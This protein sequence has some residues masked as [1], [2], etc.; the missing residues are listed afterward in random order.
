MDAYLAEIEAGYA[1][2]PIRHAWVRVYVNWDYLSDFQQAA[3][4]A[5]RQAAE[6]KVRRYFPGA[7]WNTDSAV[8]TY[9]NW[10]Q[11]LA[12][13]SRG[14]CDATLAPTGP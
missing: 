14:T 3:F 8:S 5:R 12:G 13:G 2:E 10:C 11:G 6:Q 9:R 4:I 7:N 1:A